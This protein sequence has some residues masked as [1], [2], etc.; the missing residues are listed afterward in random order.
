MLNKK[1]TKFLSCLVAGLSIYTLS[2]AEPVAAAWR[3]DSTGWWNTK[4][5]SYSVGWDKID[6]VWY[7]FDNIGYMKTGWVPYGG[8]W[9]Y[10]NGDGSMKTSGWVKY[11]GV[12]YYMNSDGTMKTS[13]WVVEGNK[14]YYIGSDGVMKTGKFTASGVNYTADSTGNAIEDKAPLDDGGLIKLED[15]LST[16]PDGAT[17][18]AKEAKSKILTEDKD[19]LAKNLKK[20]ATKSY[21]AF[22]DQV[23]IYDTDEKVFDAW[24]IPKGQYYLFKVSDFDKDGNLVNDTFGYLV[25]IKSQDIYQMPNQGMLDAY[26]IKGNSVVKTYKYKDNSSSIDWREKFDR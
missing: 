13:G 23:A 15:R 12:Y 2:A 16:T 1:I 10:M 21:C 18:N 14:R 17:L 25:D 4:G 19:F 7:Y 26:K 24:A 22:E 8:T 6:G 9:Y 11:N 5:S 20:D 3:Q